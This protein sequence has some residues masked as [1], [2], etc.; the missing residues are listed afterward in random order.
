MV[1]VATEGFWYSQ[2]PSAAIVYLYTTPLSTPSSLR[3]LAIDLFWLARLETCK[4]CWRRPTMCVCTPP[5]ACVAANDAWSGRGRR[6]WTLRYWVAWVAGAL[7]L[8]TPDAGSRVAPAAL[9]SGR[10][11]R[12]LLRGLA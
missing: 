7:G 5:A 8:A 10:L 9:G 1:L 3:V 11:L 4:K 12:G 2:R 6:G